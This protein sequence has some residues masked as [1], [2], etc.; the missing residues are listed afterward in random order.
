M[1]FSRYEIET[2]NLSKIENKIFT[3][4]TQSPSHIYL[5]NS[6]P[7]CSSLLYGT[8]P[9]QTLTSHLNYDSGS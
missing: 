4:Y 5:P 7:V 3:S 1:N 2:M 8:T 9:V 6:L